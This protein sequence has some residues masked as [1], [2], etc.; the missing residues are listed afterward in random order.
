MRLLMT[1]SVVAL[2]SSSNMVSA[3]CVS[4]IQQSNYQPTAMLGLTFELGSGSPTENMGITAKIL[5]TNEANHFVVG[6]GVS[7]FPAA[8]TKSKIGIDAGVGMNGSNISGLIGYD[9]IRNNPELS[10]GWAPTVEDSYT[11]PCPP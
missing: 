2:I 1:V 11:V 5:S 4:P 9:F 3:Q 8:K 6:G 7:F 10:A